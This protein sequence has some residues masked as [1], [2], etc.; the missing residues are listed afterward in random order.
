MTAGGPPTVPI[1]SAAD[2]FSFA[3]SLFEA[4]GLPN[5][6]ASVI[7]AGT[8]RHAGHLGRRGE[9][10]EWVT[11]QGCALMCTVNGHGYGRGVAPPGGIEGRI[12]TNP[13]CLGVPTPGGPLVLD[14]GTSVVAEGKV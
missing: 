13:L 2:L 11:Q 9:Y 7:A 6:E 14:I 8:L 3:R 10:A 1:I 5:D 4:A 12:G